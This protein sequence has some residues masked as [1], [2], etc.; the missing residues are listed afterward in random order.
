M[1]PVT[2]KT[3]A[4]AVAEATTN[5][6]LSMSVQLDNQHHEQVMFLIIVHRVFYYSSDY[7]ATLY[8]LLLFLRLM[9]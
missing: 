3:A 5:R 6:L 2:P 4:A 1:S 9:H 8:L 7:C